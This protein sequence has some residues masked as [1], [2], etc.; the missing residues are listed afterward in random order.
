MEFKEVKIAAFILSCIIC[1]YWGVT[2]V[3]LKSFPY[4]LIKDQLY[5]LKTIDYLL[6]IDDELFESRWHLEQYK[7]TGLIYKAPDYNSPNYTLFTSTHDYTA[8]LLNEKGEVIHTWD[9]DFD[10]VWHDQTHMI[11]SP[12]GPP[13][14][15]DVFYLRDFEVFPNGD[16]IFA[17]HGMGITPWGV[18]LVKLDKDSNVLWKYAGFVN[19]DFEM[20]KDGKIYAVV[21]KIKETTAKDTAITTDK[22]YLDDHI[23]L[24]NENGEEVKRFSLIE[25]FKNSK[26]KEFLEQLEDRTDLGGDLFHTNAIEIIEPT[27]NNPDWM[28][29]G[30]LLLSIRNLHALAVFNPEAGEITHLISMN[31]RM[32]HDIDQLDNGNLMLFDNRGSMNGKGFSRAIEF[33]PATLATIWEYDGTEELPLKNKFWGEQKRLPNGNTIIVDAEKGRIIEVTQNKD[34]VWDYRTPLFKEKDGVKYAPAITHAKRIN[35]ATFTFLK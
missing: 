33:D 26:Y 27:P 32:Q 4:N 13:L 6:N 22:F 1:F 7:D 18:G 29:P 15:K 25:A 2:T 23:A 5:T 10:K 35:P 28:V 8:R 24:I 34:I 30:H 14:T 11:A 19:N 17:I 12:L 3:A 20:R 9:M 16:I 31:T 21:H